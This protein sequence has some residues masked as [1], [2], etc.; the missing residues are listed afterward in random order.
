MAIT[1]SQFESEL[2]NAVTRRRILW[3]DGVGGYLLADRDEV[4]LGQAVAGSSADIGIVGDIR[5]RAG[6]IRR[7]GADYLLQPLQATQLNGQ[8]IDRAQLLRHND[9]IQFGERVRFRFTQPHP[10]SATA[11]LELVGLGKF[12]PHVDAVLLMADSCLIGPQANCHVYCP[13]WDP[14]SAPLTLVRRSQ[15]WFFNAVQELLVHG[16]PQRGLIAAAPGLRLC[17]SDFSLSIE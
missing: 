17:G 16:V 15:D 10:L 1:M 13:Q 6:V 2:A 11:R 4:T 5:R 9:L 8:A 12:Q 7:S 14:A 3:V